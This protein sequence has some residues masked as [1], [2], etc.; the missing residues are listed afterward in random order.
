MR[1]LKEV[2]AATMVLGYDVMAGEKMAKSPLNRLARRI[3]MN[4][5]T[6]AGDTKIEAL[7]EG[8]SYGEFSNCTTGLGITNDHLVPALIPIPANATFQLKCTDAA[9][10]NPV[11]VV[12]EFEP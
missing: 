4:G 7:V 2:A 6:A 9:A 1:F 8:Q 12:V 5:S 10:T 11:V 3:G